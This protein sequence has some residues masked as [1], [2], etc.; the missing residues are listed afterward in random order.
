MRKK[1]RIFVVED[2]SIVSLEIQDRLNKLGYSIAGSSVSGEK[3]LELMPDTK[4]DLILMDIMLQGKLDGIETA[5]QIKQLYDIPVIFLTAYADND[6]LQRAKLTDP[7]GY[8]IKPFE[9]RE[10]HTAIEIAI[11]KHESD[12]KLHEK[13]DWLK[14]ALQSIGDAVIATDN[15]GK[16]KFM[17]QVAEQLTGYSSGESLGK[18]LGKIFK[19]INEYTNKRIDNPVTMVLQTGKV[20]GLA[21]HSALISKD[22]TVKPIMDSASP[23]KDNKG[24][25]SG[26]VLVFQDLSE[27]KIAQDKLKQSEKKFK[28]LVEN[29]PEIIYQ[30]N[31]E[32]EILYISPKVEVI[33]GIRKENFTQNAGLWFE[34]IHPED[35]Q[36]YNMLKELSGEIV[37]SVEYRIKDNGGKWKWI[38]D[39]IT[40]VKDSTGRLIIQGFATDVT[41]KKLAEEKIT[42]QQSALNSAHNGILMTD[43]SGKVVWCNEAM[44]R[45]SG[46]NPEEI[47]GNTPKLFSSNRHDKIFYENLWKTIVNGN[48]WSGE[49]I[50]KRKNGSIYYEEMT[51]TPV[52]NNY[53]QVTHF[54][55]IKQDVTERKNFEIQIIA[56]KEQAERSDRLKSEFL[57]QISH[58]IRTP[59]SSILSFTNL[60]KSELKDKVDND[61]KIS[62]DMIDQ[63]SKRLIRT[64]DLILNMSSVQTNTYQ[65]ELKKTDLAKRILLPIIGEFEGTARVRGLKLNYKSTFKEPVYI[66]VDEYSVSQIFVNLIDN[67][68]KYTRN[69]Y[70]N[71]VL[72]GND[73]GSVLVIVEDS[74]IGISEEYLPHLFDPFTQEDQGYTRRFEGNGLGLALVKNYCEMNKAL[75]SVKSKKDEG[76]QF[77]VD[78]GE[79]FNK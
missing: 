35:F 20:I 77:I 25:I 64:I 9:E 23:I 57:A 2:E 79:S 43:K 21:N 50:N 39:R 30:T 58:E 74:G 7:Y 13:D 73:S 40:L 18:P 5:R 22:G 34:S 70:V 14:T 56:A 36:N 48:V 46:Y 24:N 78:F 11:Y 42:L 37:N 51:I 60:V 8:I 49:I 45:I 26:I 19:V 69:G 72:Q 52:K 68:I 12:R 38:E 67:A 17:N 66:N 4:P 63:G 55:S 53:D 31:K 75:I 29:S 28:E 71:V 62:F 33:L 10:L 3:T 54:I 61:I 1:N 44:T 27:R 41:D 16:I 59:I 6:T 65:L 32:L 15:E 47:I 76:T